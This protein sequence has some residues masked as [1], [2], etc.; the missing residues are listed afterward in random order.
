[1]DKSHRVPLSMDFPGKNTGVGCHFLLQRI[2]PTQGWNPCLLCLLHWQ[3]DSLPGRHCQI[4][5][6]FAKQTILS[7]TEK[8]WHPCKKLS[9]HKYGFI[10]ELPI[11]FFPPFWDVIDIVN[12]QFW[13]IDLYIYPNSSTT[14]T[15]LLPN[16][17]NWEVKVLQ[18]YSFATLFSL[19]WAPWIFYF[20]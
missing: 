16:I 6:P 17:W 19:F 4:A 12:T 2:L 9:D 15:W 11:P 1:M 7:L 13:F 14:L 20:F 18:P 5:T 3:A 8:S 10:S